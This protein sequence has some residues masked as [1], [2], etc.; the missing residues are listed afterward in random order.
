MQKLLI[1]TAM[2]ALILTGCAKDTAPAKPTAPVK[3]EHHEHK[4]HG[5]KPHHHHAHMDKKGHGYHGTHPH[6]Y[7]CEKDTKIIAHPNTESDIIKLQVTAPSLNLKDQA[8]ELKLAPSASGERYLNDANPASTY[9]WHT[10]GHDGVFTVNVGG[11]AYSY[12]CAIK[13]A[14]KR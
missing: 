3:A 14:K 7:A 4:P 12:S 11:K 1:A 8:I 5:H 6:F 10:K 13:P 2:G 9:E